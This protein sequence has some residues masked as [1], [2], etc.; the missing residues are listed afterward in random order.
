LVSFHNEKKQ[1][2]KAPTKKQRK[3]KRNHKEKKPISHI[4]LFRTRI[5]MSPPTTWGHL[6]PISS[7][8]SAR[9]RTI[10]LSSSPFLIPPIP[11]M[12]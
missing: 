4:T 11:I 8:P 2:K 6:F 12:M 9:I 7:A 10:P 3:N 1:K 5:P